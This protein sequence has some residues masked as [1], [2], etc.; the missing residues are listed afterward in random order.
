[1]P[2]QRLSLQTSS[3]FCQVDR[4]AFEEHYLNTDLSDDR[5]GSSAAGDRAM[6]SCSKER[7]CCDFF[8]L[9]TYMPSH[10]QACIHTCPPMNRRYDALLTTIEGREDGGGEEQGGIVGEG[11]ENIHFET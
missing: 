8:L 10:S 1:M 3:P 11:E 9:H 4:K 7:K 5:S 2:P 6:F